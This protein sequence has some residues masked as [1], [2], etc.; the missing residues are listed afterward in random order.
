MN[1]KFASLFGAALVFGADLTLA[2]DE[3]P[4]TIVL[5]DLEWTLETNGGYIPWPDAVDYCGALEFDGHGDWRLP[6]LVEL[7]RLYDA[8][9]DAGI[10]EPFHSDACCLWSN[11]SLANTPAEDMDEIAGDP[12]MYHWGYMFDGAQR[13][14][15]VHIFDD[16]QA[17][18]VREVN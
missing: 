18:C 12:E 14:Y 11:E 1:N 5:D 8:D 9:A 6:S 16:G 7:E 2:G 3:D 13:Y 4:A 17:L 10:R 15:A